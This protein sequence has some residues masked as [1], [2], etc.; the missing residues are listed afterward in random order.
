MSIFSVMGRNS[1]NLSMFNYLSCTI[2]LPARTSLD[3][4][5]SYLISRLDEI[6]VMVVILRKHTGFDMLQS[7]FL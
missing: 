2:I 4:L 5:V 3:V 6:F 7:L 1:L